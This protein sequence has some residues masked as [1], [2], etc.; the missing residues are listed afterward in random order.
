MA[1]PQLHAAR[2]S[3]VP[4]GDSDLCPGLYQRSALLIAAAIL[5][6]CAWEESGSLI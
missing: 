6:V 1:S 4:S 3:S 5:T 2:D